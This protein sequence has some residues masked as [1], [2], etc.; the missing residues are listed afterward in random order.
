MDHPHAQSGKCKFDFTGKSVLVTG[1][2]R[3]IGFAIAQAFAHA[4]AELYM[5][6]D[7]EAIVN[8]AS[9]I[10]QASGAVVHALQADITERVQLDAALGALTTLDVLVN[11]AGLELM[12]P[13]EQAETAA[14][15]R[16]IDINIHG[17]FAVTQTC[18]KALKASRGAIIN[19]ASIWGKS[20]EPGFS[21]YVASKHACIGL[22]RTL[23]KEL[24]PHGIRVNA[25]CPGWVRTEA[26]MRSLSRMARES[27][28]T[29]Q[30][31]LAD[32][33]ARQALPGLMEPDDVAEAYL[34]LASSAAR[35]ITGQAV[36]V[37]RG[38]VMS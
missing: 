8:A 22:T 24:A 19:T 29:E 23:A 14:F 35:N 11:N 25:I 7:D 36:T 18:L 3:G 2:S 21:A 13:I 12:T 37:D 30:E 38:E 16:I 20:A 32:I 6:A 27:G 28:R 5:L 9:T 34:F 1:A 26:S 31:L 4:G 10:A 15:Q 33:L 17:T